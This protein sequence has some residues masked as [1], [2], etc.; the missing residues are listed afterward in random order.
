MPDRGVGT[1]HLDTVTNKGAGGHNSQEQLIRILFEKRIDSQLVDCFSKSQTNSRLATIT[2]DL[3]GL[4]CLVVEFD[5]QEDA[6]EM[7]R[8]KIDTAVI[9]G[10]LTGP[11]GVVSIWVVVRCQTGI[12]ACEKQQEQV[13][14]GLFKLRFNV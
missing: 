13:V 5:A 14:R 6:M 3:G 11:D 2:P 1:F 12:P 8:A 9:H 4:H 7:V 10:Q